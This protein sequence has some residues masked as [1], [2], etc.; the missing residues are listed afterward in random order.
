MG[1]AEDSQPA[2]VEREEE[3]GSICATR[4]QST[5]CYRGKRT[6]CCNNNGL[7]ASCGC[8]AHIASQP[9]GRFAAGGI[10]ATRRQSTFC[11]QGK[12]TCC[13]N[14]NGLWASCGCSVHKASQPC[15]RY[16]LIED[17]QEGA[18]Y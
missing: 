5:F 2:L 11:Y 12:R 6:C 1:A 18:A 13:C 9:C 3:A 15:G 4:R 10:C 8:S 17:E 7:W 14:N 16:G